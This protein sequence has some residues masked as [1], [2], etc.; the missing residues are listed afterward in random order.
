M[1]LDFQIPNAKRT[2]WFI[3]LAF[4]TMSKISNKDCMMNHW[5]LTHFFEKDQLAFR[6]NDCALF[7]NLYKNWH[8]IFKFQMQ[9][10]LHGLLFLP[11]TPCLKFPTSIGICSFYIN[12]QI[13]H[14]QISKGLEKKYNHLLFLQDK[15]QKEQ[16]DLLF[17][18]FTFQYI[19]QKSRQISK[20]TIQ[21]VLFAVY[22]QALNPIILHKFQKEQKDLLFLHLTFKNINQKSRQVSKRATWFVLFAFEL[23]ST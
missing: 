13:Q 9:K 5:F 21:F 14:N 22:C 3:L 2:S 16:Q 1:A 23:L 18:H 20:R 11:S 4:N 8:W 7:S 17:L 6:V 12:H 15:F 19:I 10:E